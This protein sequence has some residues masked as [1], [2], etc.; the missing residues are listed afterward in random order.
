MADQGE[1]MKISEYRV[2]QWQVYHKFHKSRVNLL[3]H[4]VFVPVFIYGFLLLLSS[5]VL[6][7]PFGLVLSLLMMGIAF[8]AQ[9]FGHSRESEPAAPFTGISNALIRIL[10]EQLYTFPKYVL[11]GGWYRAFRGEKDSVI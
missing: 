2:K 9:G 5:L 3:I 6:L 8:A 10:L 7:K 1:K 4:I 11:T